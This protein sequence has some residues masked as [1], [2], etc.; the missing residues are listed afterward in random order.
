MS[1]TGTTEIQKTR[2]IPPNESSAH[3]AA[4]PARR[5]QRASSAAAKATSASGTSHDQP[6]DQTW[7]QTPSNAGRTRSERSAR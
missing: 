3:A 7:C 2:T 6:L 4:K 1:S 5:Q